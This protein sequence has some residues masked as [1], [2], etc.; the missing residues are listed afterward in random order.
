M[1]FWILSNL[2]SKKAYD[3][4]KKIKGHCKVLKNHLQGLLKVLKYI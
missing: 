2:F 1:R 4:A 3:L